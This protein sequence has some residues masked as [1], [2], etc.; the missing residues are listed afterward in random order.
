MT[1]STVD[2]SFIPR[3]IIIQNRQRLKMRKIVKSDIY[4]LGGGGGWQNEVV[5]KSAVLN[6]KKTRPT[7]CIMLVEGITV[8]ELRS[9]LTFSVKKVGIVTYY[10]KLPSQN[11]LSVPLPFKQQIIPISRRRHCFL[12]IRFTNIEI[13]SFDF[14]LLNL[15]NSK[16]TVKKENLV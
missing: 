8:K 10:K 5:L 16:I 15:L 1:V 2:N 13:N 12:P 6:W 4:L 3:T 9:I 14:T 7:Y 11:P